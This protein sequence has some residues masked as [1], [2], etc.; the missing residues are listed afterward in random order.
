MVKVRQV[1]IFRLQ[2]Y[3]TRSRKSAV[4]KPLKTTGK[5]HHRKTSLLKY[6][7]DFSLHHREKPVYS[8]KRCKLWSQAR[9]S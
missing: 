3:M 5:R 9:R 7:T 1:W 8:I 6:K 2:H 4:R